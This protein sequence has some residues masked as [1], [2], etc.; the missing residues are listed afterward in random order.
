MFLVRIIMRSANYLL[1]DGSQKCLLN[2]SE[3][4]AYKTFE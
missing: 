3:N 4:N 2:K 1:K